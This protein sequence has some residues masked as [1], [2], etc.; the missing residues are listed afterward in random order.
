LA[1]RYW[2][3]YLFILTDPIQP[4]PVLQC[5]N[6]IDEDEHTTAELGALNS[7]EEF[8]KKCAAPLIPVL[9]RKNEAEYSSVS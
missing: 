8:I 6:Y 1:K 2:D 7:M 9:T 3:Q 5:I 4:H